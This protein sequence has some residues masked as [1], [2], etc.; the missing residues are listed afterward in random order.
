M[1]KLTVT[2]EYKAQEDR[3]GVAMNYTVWPLKREEGEEEH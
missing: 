1:I 3:R 2:A